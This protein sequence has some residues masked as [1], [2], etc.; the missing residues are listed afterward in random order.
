M[1]GVSAR[2]QTFFRISP[3]EPGEAQ[4]FAVRRGDV[5]GGRHDVEIYKPEYTDLSSHISRLPDTTLISEIITS[6]LI[7]GFAAGKA[8]RAE[9][10]DDSVPQI[11]PTQIL[12]DGE[13]DISDAYGIRVVDISVRDYLQ[14]G[15]V[16]FNNTNSSA[17]VGKSAVFR[18]TIP[19]VCSNHVTRLH[20]RHD[21]EPEFVATVLNMLQQR[22][23]FA[24]LATNFNNQA[25]VNTATLANVR[26]PLPSPSQR[27]KLV[28]EIE[29]A[30]AERKAKLAE[31]DALLAGMDDFLLDVL[32]IS[33]PSVDSRQVF[34][35][36]TKSVGNRVDPYFHLPKFAR[37]LDALSEIH[38]TSLGSIA[39]FSKEIW[40]PKNHD[41]PTFRYIEISTVNPKTGEVQFNE[42]PTDKAP[43]RARMKVQADDIIVSL[44]RPHHGSIAH[45]GAEFEG[46][47]ASTGFAVIREVA[48]HVRR[49]YLWSVLRA[50][51]SLD[52]MIQRASGGNYPAITETEL[53]NIT[54]PVP[55]MDTQEVIA[56]EAQYR[57][58]QARSLQEQ[59]ESGWQ[60]AKQWFEEQLLG[61]PVEQ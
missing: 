17:W 35:V 33:L 3:A 60:E 1:A 21:I 22:Q 23:Y 32:G 52:Q 20:F 56:A 59:A 13:I 15:E 46:C 47:V 24:H 51:F 19:A 12:P 54:V 44:T 14:N 58:R 25:G 9:P 27:E 61:R 30:R 55:S 49:D 42:V 11:R 34:A 39:T 41:D 8:N 6:P 45:L 36:G 28:Q 16:L 53:G 43:S 31:A 40:R 57:Y 48:A 38:S 26:I 18:A 2:P 37:I 50:Q 4:C 7:S 10:G 29:A 5:T